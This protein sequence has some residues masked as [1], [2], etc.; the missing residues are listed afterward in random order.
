[1]GK[2]VMIIDDVITTG[3]TLLS[4]AESLCHIPDISISFFTLRRPPR[5]IPHTPHH[6]S[7]RSHS[8]FA[9]RIGEAQ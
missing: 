9:P 5:L 1:M 2:H 3:A 7:H 4:C 8:K 6:A